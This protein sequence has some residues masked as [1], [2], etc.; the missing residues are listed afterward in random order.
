VVRQLY[1]HGFL[2]L[3]VV[4]I[5]APSWGAQ[6]PVIIEGDIVVADGPQA[7]SIGL[8][9]DAALWPNGVIPDIR[10]VWLG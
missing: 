1:L 5:C 2:L 7:R 3:S 10:F 8:P 4:F 6:A 9:A